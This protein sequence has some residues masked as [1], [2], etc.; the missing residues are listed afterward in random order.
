MLSTGIGLAAAHCRYHVQFH[1]RHGSHWYP[2]Y[3][4]PELKPYLQSAARW[5]AEHRT[6]TFIAHS[7][8]ALKGLLDTA[9]QALPAQDLG[10]FTRP[11]RLRKAA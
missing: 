8:I 5:I 10:P 9:G 11:H 3:K 4:A 6:E 7:L 1:S 2:T